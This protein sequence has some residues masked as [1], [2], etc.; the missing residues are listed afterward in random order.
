MI[1]KKNN[2]KLCHLGRICEYTGKMCEF[3]RKIH[4]T[5]APLKFVMAVYAGKYIVINS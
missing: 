4:H 1:C 2:C 3:A 5:F